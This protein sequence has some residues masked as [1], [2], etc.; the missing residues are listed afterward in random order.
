VEQGGFDPLFTQY[1]Y[2]SLGAYIAAHNGAFLFDNSEMSRF[3]AS[4]DPAGRYRPDVISAAAHLVDAYSAA[5]GV[6]LA[7]TDQAARFTLGI[8]GWL[9]DEVDLLLRANTAAAAAAASAV[10]SQQILD[11]TVRYRETLPF[12]AAGFFFPAPDFYSLAA[13]GQLVVPTQGN[14][15]TGANDF[16]ANGPTGSIG[17]FPGTN[18]TLSVSVPAA[19]AGQV[20]AVLRGDGTILVTAL[21]GF[22]GVTWFDY[23]VRHTDGGDQGA[24]RVYVTVR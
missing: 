13:G 11:R 5:I 1:D 8:R 22:T 14:F 2:Q 23:A 20:S 24:G 12:P 9:L 4:L 21:G 7:D 16:Y 15:S 3:L 17:F 6:Q 19:N 10:T 18:E